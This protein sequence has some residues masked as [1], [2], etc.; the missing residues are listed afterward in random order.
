MVDHLNR[1]EF[2]ARFQPRSDLGYPA[3]GFPWAKNHL[4]FHVRVSAINARVFPDLYHRHE[5]VLGEAEKLG[6]WGRKLVIEAKACVERAQVERLRRDISH[7]EGRNAGNGKRR[8]IM[9][10]T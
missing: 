5:S 9:T 7:P 1:A 4:E 3:N 2:E 10:A 8:K 6:D